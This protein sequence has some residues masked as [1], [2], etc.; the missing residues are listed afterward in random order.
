MSHVYIKTVSLLKTVSEAIQQK[1]KGARVIW[2]NH[3]CTQNLLAWYNWYC[4]FTINLCVLRARYLIRNKQ[5][6]K[7]QKLFS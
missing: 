7:R 3:T 2:Q 5:I 4:W 1:M 6:W